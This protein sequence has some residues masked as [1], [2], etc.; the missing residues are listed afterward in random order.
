LASEFEDSPTLATALGADGYDH[1]LGDYS[2]EGFAA[3]EE[4]N[5]AWLARFSGLADEDL[6]SDEQI[7]RDLVRST[8]RGRIV[9]TDWQVWRR[10][11]AVYLNPG[12]SGVFSLF[13]NRLHDDN[14]L[15]AS[16]CARLEQVPRVLEA[17]K[18]NIDETLASPIFVDRAKGQCGAGVTYARK[19]VPEEAESA[20]NRE[21]LARAG[22][23][24]AAAYEDFGR[25]LES[26]TPTGPY[27]IGE[28]R[29][30]ALLKD[31]EALGYGAREMLERGRETHAALDA[32]LR[33]LAVDIGGSDDWVSLVQELSKNHP[34]T[35]DA[36]RET[37]EEWTEKARQFLGG[38]GLVTLPPG[39]E[40]LVVPSP[41]FQ[42]PVLAVA[43]YNPP[44]AFRP[45]LRGHFFVPYPPDGT[46]PEDI[47]KR[48]EANSNL[49][50]PTTSVHEAYPG[51]HWHF[52]VL[53]GNPRI[54]RKILGSSYFT[55][56]WALYAELMMRE[57]GFYDDPV[58]ILGML[59]ARIFRAARIVV[60]TS[61]HLG[62]M[63]FDEAV[64]FM[65]AN[66]LPE[67]T[68]KAEVGRYCSWPTQAPSYLTGSLEIERMRERYLREKRG[69][70]K[71]FHDSIAGS[72]M[73]PIG[74]AERALF[75]V[76][77][78]P[79]ILP[80]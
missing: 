39:E 31:K 71:A 54:I 35:P 52:A 27:A 8:L 50:I 70:L 65:Q 60:D 34:P 45:S 49:D 74:L 11:P 16:A 55:E 33:K 66:G 28:Q 41:P 24:A 17:G 38:R 62:D 5:R 3:R 77:S 76:S 79:S 25:F 44:P 6:L 59:N 40:C 1:L 10:N 18:A 37:Y 61:L 75:D 67:P 14:E 56:G 72:G 30:S 53:H 13:L 20:Q 46:S 12:L 23:I 32:E 4:K 2:A 48:L 22:E 73:L 63:T 9:M 43:S 69:D 36:M 78:A 80:T 15:T 29:Y 51:H 21:A 58:H 42:R 57:E 47:A 26:L 7:D 19:L 68:A 64:A